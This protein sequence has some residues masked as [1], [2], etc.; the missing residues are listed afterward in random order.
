MIMN[1]KK[2]QHESDSRIEINGQTID[3]ITT[4]EYLRSILS[5]D[6]KIDLRIIYRSRNANNIFYA[7]NKEKKKGID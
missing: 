4:Y 5:H 2:K 1:S 7:I 3:T 6:G